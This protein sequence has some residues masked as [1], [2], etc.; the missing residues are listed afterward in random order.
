MHSLY[1][2]LSLSHIREKVL[3]NNM[4]MS[5]RIFI[6]DYP[7][8]EMNLLVGYFFRMTYQPLHRSAITMSAYNIPDPHS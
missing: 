3:L 5:F 4:V 6:S 8:R 7:I 1:T 2:K